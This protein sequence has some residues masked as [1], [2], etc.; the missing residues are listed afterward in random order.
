MRL[1]KINQKK[2]IKQMRKQGLVSEPTGD[3]DDDWGGKATENSV[4][5][6]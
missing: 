4:V 6:Y 5:Y 2:F 1:P 3:D